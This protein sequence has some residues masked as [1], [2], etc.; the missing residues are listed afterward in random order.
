[1]ATAMH[2]EPHHHHE[3]PTSG[4]ALDAVALSATLHCLTGC[5]IG[6][7]AG[8]G[9]RHRPR[10]LPVG[11]GRARR[12]SRL[13]VRLLADEPAAAA[14]GPRPVRRRA[15]RARHRHLQHRGRWRSS[16]TRSCSA[17]RARWSP[18]SATCCSGAR[19]RSRSSSRA[20]SPFPVNRWLITRGKG[21]AVLHNSGHPPEPPDPRRGRRRDDG[22]PVRLG[23]PRGRGHHRRRLRDARRRAMHAAARA[24]PRPGGPRRQRAAA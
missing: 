21:H 8:H 6:E 20:S 4:R 18:G 11:H 22:L 17:S 10:L 5:A 9:D 19:C 7:V 16:T 15:D 12:R 3:L 13:P 24:P 2:D 1:M 23:R 14:R